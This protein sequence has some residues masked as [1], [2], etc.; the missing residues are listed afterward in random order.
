MTAHPVAAPSA[1]VQANLAGTFTLIQRRSK[2]TA[3]R[4]IGPRSAPTLGADHRVRVW[5][6]ALGVRAAISSSSGN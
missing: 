3:Y 2:A 1:S 4:P 6:S 5:E